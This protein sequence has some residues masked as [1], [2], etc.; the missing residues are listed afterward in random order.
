MDGILKIRQGTPDIIGAK[1]NQRVALV[2]SVCLVVEEPTGG[3]P[4]RSAV[5]HEFE[6]A[7]STADDVGDVDEVQIGVKEHPLKPTATET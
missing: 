7:S 2:D 5:R 1:A 4:S 6:S 3:R